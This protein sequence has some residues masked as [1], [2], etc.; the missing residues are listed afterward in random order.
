MNNITVEIVKNLVTIIAIII[1]G[2]WTMYRFG[3]NREKYPKLQFELNLIITGKT[4]T[5]YILQLVAIIDNK[6]LTRQYINDFKFH[7]LY[8]NNDFKIVLD[9]EKIN[10]QLKFKYLITNRDWLKPTTPP[11]IDGG[12]KHKFTYNTAVDLNIDYVIIYSKFNYPR[13]GL[14][15]KSIDR[16][17]FLK[18]LT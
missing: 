3:I 8:F 12:I 14:F 16:Y 11:F 4:S 15:R 7:L 9:D 17:I 10:R 2:I 18:R 5:N 13:K 1:A 6:G